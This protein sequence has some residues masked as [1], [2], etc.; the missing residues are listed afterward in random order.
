MCGHVSSGGSWPDGIRIPIA[1]YSSKLRWSRRRRRRQPSW[2]AEI[3]LL[4]DDRCRGARSHSRRPPARRL[5][6]LTTTTRDF[7]PI[8]GRRDASGG[9]R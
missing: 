6:T 3:K 4:V 2:L 1:R 5:D 9:R 8:A 7:R